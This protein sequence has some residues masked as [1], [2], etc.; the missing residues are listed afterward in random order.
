[1]VAKRAEILAKIGPGEKGEGERGY[2]KEGGETKPT[3][4]NDATCVVL[5]HH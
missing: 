4:K 3:P 5:T 1:M 2:P